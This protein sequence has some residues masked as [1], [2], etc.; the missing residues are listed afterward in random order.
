MSALTTPYSNPLQLNKATVLITGGSEGIGLGFVAELVAAGSQ[1]I[2]T[3]RRVDA[4]AKAK[5]TFP[6]IHTIQSDVAS[7]EQRRALVEQV[8][9]AY[10]ALNVVILN[11]G[12]LY[13]ATLTGLTKNGT[14][15]TD[16]W[17]KRQEEIDINVS[18]PV[19]LTSLFVPHLLKQSEAAIVY[20]S[21]LFAS[22]PS[23]FSPSYSATKAFVHNFAIGAREYLNQSNVHVYEINPP[24]VK[25]AL[26]GYYGEEV[27]A[28]SKGVIDRMK[29]GQKEIG[30]GM[31]EQTRLASRE[32]QGKFVDAFTQ[33]AATVGL[34]R[35]YTAAK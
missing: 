9:K 30:F 19:H 2:I 14:A 15:G 8:T 1:V 7:E 10:P 33:Q 24:L 26:S 34:F 4:L 32:E 27:G 12:V 28:F 31:S 13:F 35:P 16:D 22:A 20:V 25:T 6:S 23:V 21:S 17:A 29:K 18:A 5:K 3:G 11:A